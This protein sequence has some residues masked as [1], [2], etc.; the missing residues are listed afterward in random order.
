[1]KTLVIGIRPNGELHLGHYFGI[2][3]NMVLMQYK[4]NCY[5]FIANIHSLN[6]KIDNNL[7]NKY[8]TKIVAQYIAVGL[9]PNNV[10]LYI[11][12]QIDNIFELY[13]YLSINTYLGEL[14]RTNSLKDIINKNG[15]CNIALL[16]YPILMAADILIHNAHY[17]IVGQDQ[18]QH[19]EIAKKIAIRFNKLYNVNYFNLP[20]AYNFEYN[21]NNIL[22][23][24][25]I[26]KMGK[27]ISNNLT[28]YL[29]DNPDIIKR[30][31][32]KVP[33]DN[34][35]RKHNKPMNPSVASLFHLMNLT[36]SKQT[37]NFFSNEYK[38]MTI[39]YNDMKNQLSQ[40]II[41]L[42]TPIQNKTEELLNYKNKIIDIIQEGAIKARENSIN[43][44]K[45]LRDII[46]II[47][48]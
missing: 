25:G 11:Q 35:L 10:H 7:I 3:K 16:T 36:S 30:K 42:L 31:I 21:L 14:K 5:C 12:S 15:N 43:T 48:L 20:N 1:M 32:R 44:I 26:N 46:G 8:I 38:K 40:D 22:A 4:F 33:T 24:D 27:S 2:L 23:L 17:A 29:S 37:Y 18:K 19:L 39:S 45:N 41:N 9:N 6:N 47:N 34:S 13:Y 28:I